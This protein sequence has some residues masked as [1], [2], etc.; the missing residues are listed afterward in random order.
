M[1]LTHK[2]FIIIA[3]MLGAGCTHVAEILSRKLGISY[4]NSEKILREI[5]V[6]KGISYAQ[7]AQL[8]SSGEVDI[9]K[10]VRSELLDYVN[11]R[12]IIIEGRS[13]LIVLDR[14]ADIKVFLWA[15][16]DYR[17]SL[18]AKR[19]KISLDEA[20][21]QVQISDEERRNLVRRLHK[22]DWLDL[23]LYDLVINTGKW[24][25]EEVAEIILNAYRMRLKK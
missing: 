18:V 21:E 24:S 16:E 15:P 19:R 13:G 14:E 25:Y 9:E 4:I 20:L 8:V 10:L 6:E 3:G 22:R 12:N 2:P 7:F 17:A 5:V 11:E 1:P 23:N